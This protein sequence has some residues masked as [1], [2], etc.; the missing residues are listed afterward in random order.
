M[1]NALKSIGKNKQ[2]EDVEDVGDVGDS[3]A[4]T[5]LVLEGLD[6]FKFR[7][8]A[9]EYAEAGAQLKHATYLRD[10]ERKKKVYEPL[11][12]LVH[13]QTSRAEEFNEKRKSFAEYQKEIAG[14]FNIPL[15]KMQNSTVDTNTGVIHVPPDEEPPD[16]ESKE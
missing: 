3:A 6:L 10:Q 16:E 2:V 1:L 11:I 15:D 13:R 9:A 12:L 4:G 8:L 5:P 14:R 7:A